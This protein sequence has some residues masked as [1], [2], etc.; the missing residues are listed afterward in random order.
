MEKY[1]SKD[2]WNVETCKRCG[3][4]VKVNR[5]GVSTLANNMH[6]GYTT[7]TNDR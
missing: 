5:F 1:I 2:Q 6:K 3:D 7:P 4:Q